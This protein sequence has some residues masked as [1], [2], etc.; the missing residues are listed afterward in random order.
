MAQNRTHEQGVPDRGRER[1]L[2]NDSG[3]VRGLEGWIDIIALISTKVFPPGYASDEM[4]LEKPPSNA[5]W[6]GCVLVHTST[7]PSMS[8]DNPM[9]G[10]AARLNPSGNMCSSRSSQITQAQPRR[11][12]AFAARR[13]FMPVALLRRPALC[14]SPG[15]HPQS[16]A[17][18]PRPSPASNRAASARVTQHRGVCILC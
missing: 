7:H 5:L 15:T 17:R 4:N 1:P 12:S 9:N 11:T 18:L 2:A 10:C 8:E 16:G 6:R 3:N 13:P 14:R